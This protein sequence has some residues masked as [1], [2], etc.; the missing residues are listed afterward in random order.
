MWASARGNEGVQFGC[1]R[2]SEQVLKIFTDKP[3]IE[4]AVENEV[5]I[6]KSSKNLSIDGPGD[7][8]DYDKANEIV[9]SRLEAQTHPGQA[10][11]RLNSPS[12]FN[13]TFNLGDP[14]YQMN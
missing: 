14:A 9:R 7:T 13:Q 10:T 1:E 11:R 8:L 3:D 2:V 4:I 6:L 5:I 12:P